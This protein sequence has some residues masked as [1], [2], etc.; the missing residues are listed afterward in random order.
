MVV[1]NIS[2]G[3]VVGLLSSAEEQ[4]SQE[5][6]AFLKRHGQHYLTEL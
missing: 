5:I 2:F 4:L 1:G 3:E 6:N